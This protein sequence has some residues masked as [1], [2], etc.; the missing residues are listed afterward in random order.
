MAGFFFSQAASEDL[1]NGKSDTWRRTGN[2]MG[3]NW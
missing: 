2:A 3:V 1:T